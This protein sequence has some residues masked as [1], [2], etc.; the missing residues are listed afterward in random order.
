[1]YGVE[2]FAGE[3]AKFEVE[4]SDTEVHAQWKLKGVALSPSAVS[5]AHLHVS[6][7]PSFPHNPV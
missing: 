5:T 3:T 7:L 1:M 4:V 2:L 6:P